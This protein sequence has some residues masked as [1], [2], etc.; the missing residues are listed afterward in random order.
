MK[1]VGFLSKLKRERKLQLI[2]ESVEVCEAYL[3]KSGNCLK[4]SKILL[5]EEIYE[6]AVSEAYYAMYNATLSLFFRCGIKCENHAAAI[7][8]L[9]ELF[10]LSD[11]A[12]VL[13]D[14]KKE[15]IDA[16]YYVTDKRRSAIDED[17][18]VCMV[19]DAE[20]FVFQIRSYIG[21]LTGSL[22]SK[23][24]DRFEAL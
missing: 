23:I 17:S 21:K 14:A 9:D 18:A 2:E 12:K 8:L 3:L 19:T 5:R 7:M 20:E 13:A 24:R 15:R 11:L 16:Q 4:S 1:K 6:N 10:R 22:I